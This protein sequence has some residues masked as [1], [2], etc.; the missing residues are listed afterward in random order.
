MFGGSTFVPCPS[1]I[2]Q[3][4]QSSCTCYCYPSWTCC[5]PDFPKVCSLSQLRLYL[6]TCKLVG[7]VV[8]LKLISR[9]KSTSS[10]DVSLSMEWI[11]GGTDCRNV[12]YPCRGPGASQWYRGL[13]RWCSQPRLFGRDRRRRCRANRHYPVLPNRRARG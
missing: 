6:P 3:N 5:C 10:L 12:R 1:T 11:E 7:S 2:T 4:D 13:Q 8:R 9:I